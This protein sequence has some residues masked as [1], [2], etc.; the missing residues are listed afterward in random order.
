M[1]SGYAAPEVCAGR[2]LS[3]ACDWW[4]VGALLYELL[5]GRSL[6]SCHPAGLTTHSVLHVPAHVSPE[7]ASL[8]TQLLRVAPAERLNALEI[9]THAF[10]SGINWH[11][12]E[13]Y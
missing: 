8:L 4:S 3:L 12:L 7:A 10:F 13:N 2:S 9:K 11:D 5:T 6:V 1:D